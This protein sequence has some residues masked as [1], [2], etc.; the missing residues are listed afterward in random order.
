MLFLSPFTPYL[1]ALD[2]SGSVFVSQKSGNRIQVVFSK[3]DPIALLPDPKLLLVAQYA[4]DGNSF[5]G[6][7]YWIGSLNGSGDPAALCCSTLS[8]LQN[9]L[10][11]IE[12]FTED[13]V[14]WYW[15]NVGWLAWWSQLQPELHNRPSIHQYL[16][17]LHHQGSLDKP[18]EMWLKHEVGRVSHQCH[19]AQRICSNVLPQQEQQ[20]NMATCIALPDAVTGLC[21]CWMSGR[22]CMM[23][24]CLNRSR[25]DTAWLGFETIA[26]PAGK[27]CRNPF[28]VFATDT[29]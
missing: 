22:T 19:I 3:N 12:A 8:E 16:S 18:P 27:P 1:N 17:S 26:K 2:I 20:L 29:A 9:P 23:R 7:E 6:N 28:D 5:A 25:L 21:L 11:N 4:W 10:I 13:K 15:V 24:R 14:R